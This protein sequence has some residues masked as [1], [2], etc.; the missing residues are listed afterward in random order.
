MGDGLLIAGIIGASA[1]VVTVMDKYNVF[2]TN[3]TG[4]WFWERPPFTA[5]PITVRAPL[6][7]ALSSEQQ[8]AQQVAQQQ[9][10][11]WAIA[12]SQSKYRV[13]GW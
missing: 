8:H 7:P 5:A 3:P 13:S 6:R 4:K 1:V 9:A 2:Q 10:Q 12:K 11:E